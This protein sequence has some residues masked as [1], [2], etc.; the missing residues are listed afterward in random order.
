[1]K[2]LDYVQYLKRLID[3]S[4]LIALSNFTVDQRGSDIAFI[5]G[6]LIFVDGSVLDFREF[7]QVTPGRVDKYKYAYNYRGHEGEIIFRYDNAD[8]PQARQFETYP[9]HKHTCDGLSEA[10]EPSL[11]EVLDEISTY[12]L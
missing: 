4:A 12:I 7:I 3:R 1:M 6:R 9:A 2:L 5:K 11:G 10:E 8:D